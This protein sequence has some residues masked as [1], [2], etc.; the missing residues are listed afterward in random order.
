MPNKVAGYQ[1]ADGRFFKTK[2]EAD[3]E[4]S[5]YLLYLEASK[6]IHFTP[7]SFAKWF[8]FTE[9]YADLVKLHCSNYLKFFKQTSTAQRDTT[10]EN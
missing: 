9:S 7:E 8:A 6:A 10:D 2:K 4:E 1:T 3:Y 5:K